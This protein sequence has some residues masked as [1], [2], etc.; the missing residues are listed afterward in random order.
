MNLEDCF[1][2][3]LLIKIKADMEKA[4]RSIKTAEHKLELALKEYKAGIYEGSIINAY[5]SLFHSARAILFKDGIKER[6][7]YAI[8]VYLKEK[9]GNKIKEKLLNEFSALRLQRH[10]ILYG[11]SDEIEKIEKEEAKEILSAA[12]EFV[13]KVKEIV[14]H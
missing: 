3:R 8:Y 11:F 9:Y 5:A 13:F 10:E 1:S 2:K 14:F 7:H 6:S 4:E 12:E